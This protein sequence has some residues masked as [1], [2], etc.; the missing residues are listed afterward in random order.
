MLFLCSGNFLTSLEFCPEK[1][2]GNFNCSHNQLTSLQGIGKKYLKELTGLLDLRGNPIQSH[3]LGLLLINGLQE[4]YLNNKEVQE[5]IN[6]HLA[7]ERDIFD[8]QEEL[9][10]ASFREF[11]K[12]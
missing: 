12:L 2:H 7:G 4:V 6:K 9:I 11:A 1:I 3:V 10:Q 8:C 5:I